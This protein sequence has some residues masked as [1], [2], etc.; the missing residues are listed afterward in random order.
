M[1]AAGDFVRVLIKLT[2]CMQLRH[3]D[4]SGGDAFFRVK[5]GGNAATI[6][7]YRDRAVG[8]EGYRDAGCMARQSFVNGVIDDFIHHV[9]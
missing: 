6:I 1:K 4:F 9:M 2:A 5:V 7:G 3:D 8:V